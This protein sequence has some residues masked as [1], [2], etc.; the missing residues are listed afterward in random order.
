[1]SASASSDHRRRR[2]ARV[3]LAGLGLVAA[4]ELVAAASAY[5]TTVRSEHWEAARIALEASVSGE[6]VFLATDWLGPRA[7]MALPPLAAP[8]SAAR[9]DLRGSPRYAVLGLHSAW[10]DALEHDL[11]DLPAPERIEE[12][13]FGPLVLT[14]YAQ[15]GAGERLADLLAE[16]ARLQV[17]VDGTR[18]KGQSRMWRCNLGRAYP[19]TAE[20]D[21]RPRRCI[22]VEADDGVPVRI[23]WPQATTGDVVRGHVGFHDFN[24][25]LRSDAPAELTVFVD[26]KPRARVLATDQEGWRPFAVRTSPGVHDLAVE[27]VVAA[28]GTWDRRG[29]DAGAAHAPCVELRTL[30]EARP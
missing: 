24:R 19:V 20:I 11:E 26:G 14:R 28:R 12:T 1:M 6:P 15:P 22:A 25:R 4:I 13:A 9:P 29:Y 21:Y 8:A 10:S 2:L 23:E 27:V 30:Q 5:R 16:T 7:R 3:T 17:F 18:C